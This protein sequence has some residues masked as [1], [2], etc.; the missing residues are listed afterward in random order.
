M[1]E[2][3]S[4][5]AMRAAVAVVFALLAAACAHGP[6]PRLYIGDTGADPNRKIALCPL[7]APAGG[8]PAAAADFNAGVMERWGEVLRNTEIVGGDAA[9]AL[10][11]ADSGDLV[12]G[13]YD[14]LESPDKLDGAG[15]RSRARELLRRAFD[16]TPAPDAAFAFVVGDR[17]AYERGE[18]L[19]LHIGV[20]AGDAALWR[21]TAAIRT[22]KAEITSYDEAVAAL[23]HYAFE[24]VQ[25]TGAVGG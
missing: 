25:H 23:I 2:P 11:S 18:A 20:L 24:A 21:F 5:P 17:A 4:V 14:A 16:T 7:L 1:G 3:L 9:R 15:V 22:T 10:L 12:K 19:E 8:A 13:V 6:K